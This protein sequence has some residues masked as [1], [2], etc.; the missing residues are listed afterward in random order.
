MRNK[1]ENEKGRASKKKVRL[2]LGIYIDI[3][4]QQKVCA[5]DK[6]V[7]FSYSNFSDFIAMLAPATLLPRR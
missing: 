2:C 6:F 7:L 5:F 4:A 3:N 1:D